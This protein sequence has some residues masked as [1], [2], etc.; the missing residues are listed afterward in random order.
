MSFTINAPCLNS[1]AFIGLVFL[2]FKSKLM[3]L[4]T[5]YTAKLKFKDSL[6]K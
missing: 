2:S 1:S 4:R 3:F 6:I 5:I